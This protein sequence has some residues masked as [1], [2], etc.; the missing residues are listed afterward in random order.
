MKN[1]LIKSDRYQKFGFWNVISNLYSLYP[2]LLIKGA[3]NSQF[4]FN[5][6]NFFFSN[7]TSKLDS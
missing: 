7:E 3:A 6:R 1:V 2:V 4:F 5:I